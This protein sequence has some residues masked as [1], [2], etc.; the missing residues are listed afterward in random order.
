[1]LLPE[2]MKGRN[3]TTILCHAEESHGN[4]EGKTERRRATKLLITII[5]FR[6]PI[7]ALDRP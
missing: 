5:D 1:M 6:K 4:S 7:P 3:V 2:G